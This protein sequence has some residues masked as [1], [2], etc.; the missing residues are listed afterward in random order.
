MQFRDKQ[1][2]NQAIQTTQFDAATLLAK[3]SCCTWPKT[4]Y[5]T[6]SQ[7]KKFLKTTAK[8][9]ERQTTKEAEA[10]IVIWFELQKIRI[11][12]PLAKDI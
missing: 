2:E 5:S 8:K 11:W 1:R 12:L 3:Y 7:G 10:N 4:Q 6:K 9:D